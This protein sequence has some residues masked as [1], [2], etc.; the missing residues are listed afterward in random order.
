MIDA[1]LDGKPERIDEPEDE[2]IPYAGEESRGKRT[3]LLSWRMM[4]TVSIPYMDE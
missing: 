3:M 1:Y 4:N 2:V